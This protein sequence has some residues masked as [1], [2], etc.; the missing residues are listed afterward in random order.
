MTN[1]VENRLASLG[2]TLPTPAAPAANYVPFVID[3][4]YL[5]VSGQLPMG[6]DGLAFKGKLGE[7]FNIPDGQEAA[8]LCGLNILAQAKA[9]LG[10]FDRLKQLVKL[11]G[12]VN[13]TPDFVDH[14]VVING[15][16]DL[17]AAVLE[18]RGQ[19]ARFAVGCSGLPFGAAVEVDALFSIE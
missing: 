4:G 13:A 2:L 8:R 1:S 16:S 7:T 11:G 5:F 6:P 18:E 9:A 14:P 19:H 3:D 12:F 17:M 10:D 15:A